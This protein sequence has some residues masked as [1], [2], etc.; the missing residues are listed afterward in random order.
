MLFVPGGLAQGAWPKAGLRPA[1]TKGAG[2]PR[3]VWIHRG[4]VEV[5]RRD[6]GGAPHGRLGVVHVDRPLPHGYRVSPARRV[7]RG[8]QPGYSSPV[9]SLLGLSCMMVWNCSS[10]RPI[11]PPRMAIPFVER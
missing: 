5:A 10:V 4:L 6:E 11:S 3:V 7:W 2:R 9:S 8:S 1:P